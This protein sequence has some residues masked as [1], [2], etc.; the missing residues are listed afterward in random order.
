MKFRL[1]WG[2]FVVIILVL[3][4]GIAG[5]Y[6]NIVGGAAHDHLYVNIYVDN[7]L[8]TEI[9][10]ADTQ[11]RIVE[12]PFGPDNE[13]QAEVE[14][15]DGK[16]RMLPM[17]EELCPRRICTHTGWISNYGE[18]IACLPNK[19]LIVFDQVGDSSESDIDG[20]TY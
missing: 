12:V 15:K 20:I 13:H 16:V 18:S 4:L 9:S 5:L 3:A 14:I 8:K 10:L 2:D 6:N 17:D 7:E 19:I 1:V 11:D